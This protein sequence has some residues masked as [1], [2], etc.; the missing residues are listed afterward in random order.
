MNGVQLILF[1]MNIKRFLR[2]FITAYMIGLASM[3][4]I[5]TKRKELTKYQI[6]LIEEKEEDFKNDM[7]KNMF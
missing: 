1:F 6:E 4:P 3:F 7:V 5:M 2:L